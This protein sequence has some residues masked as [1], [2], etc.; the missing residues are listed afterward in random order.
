LATKIADKAQ[1]LKSVQ[2]LVKAISTEG[3]D[4]AALKFKLLVL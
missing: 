2:E 4:I 1:Q 3:E